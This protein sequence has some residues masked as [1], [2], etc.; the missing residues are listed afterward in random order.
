MARPLEDSVGYFEERIV[1]AKAFRTDRNCGIFGH[2]LSI[3]N[4]KF[5]A[6]VRSRKIKHAPARRPLGEGQSMLSEQTH[7]GRAIGT[8]IL[9][10]HGSVIREALHVINEC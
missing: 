6:V 3:N 10:L 9:R 2:G 8:G 1:Q 5:G 4:H 7:H